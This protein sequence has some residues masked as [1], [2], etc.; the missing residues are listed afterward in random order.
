MTTT[1]AGVVALLKSKMESLQVSG[2]TV[3]ETVLDYADGDFQTYPAC[4]I[5]ED[6]GRGATQ[7]THRNVRTHDITIRFY[8]EQSRAGKTK[9][10]AAA[11]MRA[12]TDAALIALDT[13]KTLSGG[14]DIVKVVSFDTNFRVAAGTFNF[15]TIKVEAQVLVVNHN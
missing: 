5:T 14:V 2:Q 3:F 7:D 13:D 9:A 11:I 10:E 15:A 12:I 1:I 4:T 8:Q 6:G